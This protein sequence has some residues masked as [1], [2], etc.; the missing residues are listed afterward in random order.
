MERLKRKTDVFLLKWKNSADKLPLIIKG[1]RQIGKTEA[2]EH[3][4]R[5]NYKNIV[6]INFALQ[7]QYK[8][9]IEQQKSRPASVPGG[10]GEEKSQ[11][12]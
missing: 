6:E 10:N 7:K 8:S 11:K 5:N 1:A 3:F 4:A 2:V 9:S 12:R